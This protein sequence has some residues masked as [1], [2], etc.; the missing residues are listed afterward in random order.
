MKIVIDTNIVLSA[1][2]FNSV[3][4]KECI[5][6]IIHDTNIKCFANDEI[7]IEYNKKMEEKS[8]SNYAHF[9]PYNKKLYKDFLKSLI[10]KPTT[11]SISICRDLDDNKFINCAWENKCL[12]IISGDKDLT[13][14][15]V[16]K[17]IQFIKVVEFLS[18]YNNSISGKENER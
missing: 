17:D 5:E 1:L 15:R 7:L 4:C 13:D 2:L 3:S 18:I 11:T 8:K 6:D 10:I 14:I 12:Y 9:S 16:Y